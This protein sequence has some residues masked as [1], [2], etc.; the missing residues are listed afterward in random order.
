MNDLY[1][2]DTIMAT[3]WENGIWIRDRHT[4]HFVEIGVINDVSKNE[5]RIMLFDRNCLNG[6]QYSGD[7]L[8]SLMSATDPLVDPLMDQFERYVGQEEAKVID[9]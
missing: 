5:I 6:T 9:G 1:Q 2:L 3:G 4:L 8:F 7:E